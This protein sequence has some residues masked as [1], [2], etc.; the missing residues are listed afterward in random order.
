LVRE[1]NEVARAF[2]SRTIDPFN[3]SNFGR[4]GRKMLEIRALR[5]HGEN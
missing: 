2:S 3:R 1:L 4:V 5:D